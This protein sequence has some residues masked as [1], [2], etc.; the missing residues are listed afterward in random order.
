VKKLVAKL[1][2]AAGFIRSEVEALGSQP[3]EKQCQQE[4]FSGT[5]VLQSNAPKNKKQNQQSWYS[6][7]IVL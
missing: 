3:Q 1:K 4:V 6:S 2:E 7:N 5:L